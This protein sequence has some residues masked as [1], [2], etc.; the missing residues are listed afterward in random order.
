MMADTEISAE[1]RQA[2]RLIF[3]GKAPSGQRPCFHC[4]GVHLRACRRVKSAEWHTDGTVIKAEYWPDGAWD[5]TGIIWP[6]DAY[7]DDESDDEEAAP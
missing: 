4:G 3:E 7:E 6:E 5:E 1:E 2:A